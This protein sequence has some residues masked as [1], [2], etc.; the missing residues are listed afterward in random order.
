MKEYTSQDIKTPGTLPRIYAEKETLIYNPPAW[1][2]RG[3]QETRSGYGARLNTGYSI[4]YE[5]RVYRL[6]CTCYG[7]A[8]SVWFKAQGKKIYVS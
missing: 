3:L 2:R 8:G 6:Y 5:G 4:R 7:N 1:L